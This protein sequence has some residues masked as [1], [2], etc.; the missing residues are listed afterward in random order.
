MYFYAYKFLVDIFDF[1]LY[2]IGRC[3]TSNIKRRSDEDQILVSFCFL[4]SFNVDL[5]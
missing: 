4:F 5:C 1:M 3:K 2:N